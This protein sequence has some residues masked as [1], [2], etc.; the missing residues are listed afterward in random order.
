MKALVILAGAVALLALG[1]ALPAQ[2]EGN[3]PWCAV[4]SMG[5][6]NT[7]WDCRYR[8]IEQCRPNVIA[9]KPRLLRSELFDRAGFSTLAQ[10]LSGYR[11]FRRAGLRLRGSGYSS[12]STTSRSNAVA[13]RRA[14]ST[15]GGARSS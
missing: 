2:A 12:V 3:A 9:G 14:R 11:F 15:L 13:R 1:S 4:I 7:V 8:S 10:P 6:G 5:W